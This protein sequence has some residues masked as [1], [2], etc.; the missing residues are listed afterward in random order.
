MARDQQQR[1]RDAVVVDVD[2]AVTE[3][4]NGPEK[5]LTCTSKY[6]SDNGDLDFHD[7]EKSAIVLFTIESAD[8]HRVRFP[9]DGAIALKKA[10]GNSTPHTDREVFKYVGVSDDGATLIL[11][12]DNT[13]DSGRWEYTLYV[14]VDGGPPVAMDPVIINK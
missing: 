7:V 11:V 5:R 8:G 9:G 10:H 12:D 14:Q 1:D 13:R 6:F 3:G 4:P 2:V